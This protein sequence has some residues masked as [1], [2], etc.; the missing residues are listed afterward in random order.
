MKKIIVTKITAL[1][2]LL[3]ISN[4]YAGCPPPADTLPS[5]ASPSMQTSAAKT[6]TS[7]MI[8]VHSQVWQQCWASVEGTAFSG[9]ALKSLENVKTMYVQKYQAVILSQLTESTE[10]KIAALNGGYQAIIQTLG[11]SYSALSEAKTQMAVQM[12]EMELDY[13][14]KIQEEKMNEEHYDL[15]ND[16]NGGA[17]IVDASTQSYK[18]YKNVCKRNKMFNK[19]SGAAYQA[20]RS[21]SVNES[22]TKKSKQMSEMTSS[23]NELA[24]S[25]VELHSSEFCS[26]QDIKYNQC[27]NADLELCIEDDV[28][29][30]VCK[31]STNEV[32]ELTN[33]DTDALNFLSPDGYNGSYT[34][35]GDEL[36]APRKEIKDEQFIVKETYDDDQLAA[37]E[38]FASNLIY[39][40]SVKAPTIAEKN[41]AES[42]EF[43][44]QYNKYISNLNLANY[45]FTNAIEARKPI[46]EGE[47]V[48]SEKDVMRYIIHNLQ[49]PDANAATMAAK[50]KGKEAMIYQLMTVNNKIKLNNIS[51]KERIESLLAGILTQTA[52][53]PD[54][55]NKLNSLK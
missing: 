43:I 9:D 54:L 52:N 31:I 28:D 16:G 29:S 23:T 12:L 35:E 2:S 53:D 40:P 51:Q 27:V 15:F 50:N 36:E 38:A 18:Y 33:K 44:S 7:P 8:H 25:I 37:A 26:A 4:S 1:A 49:D 22:I 42:Q 5:V 55:I 21:S 3:F 41:N 17:G 11:E 10:Q 19:T 39:Q 48:M 6:S 45:S 24:Q 30:G 47:I 34:F 20:K 46:T 14:K 32:F 13:T